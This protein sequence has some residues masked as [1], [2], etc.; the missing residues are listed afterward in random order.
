[1]KKYFLS[2][3]PF[4][5]AFFFFFA[6]QTPANA[7]DVTLHWDPSTGA[8][9]YKIQKS[10]DQGVTWLPAIDVANVQTFTYLNVEENILVF[11]RVSAYNLAG[12]SI[13]TWSGAWYDHRKKPV[14]PPP[15]AGIL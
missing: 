10:I 2:Y 11:F 5:T 15:G 12:E 1:M 3:L 7:V 4:L 6:I 14:S 9:G 8:T 13:R